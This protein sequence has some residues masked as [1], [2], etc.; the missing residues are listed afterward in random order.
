LFQVGYGVFDCVLSLVLLL[1]VVVLLISFGYCLAFK[2]FEVYVGLFLY[3]VFLV[4][5]L[6][7]FDVILSDSAIREAL[8]EGGCPRKLNLV[9]MH[10][11]SIIRFFCLIFLVQF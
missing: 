10:L 2:L 5:A 3:S 6:D 4:Y 8:R 11:I 7:S 1:H 9:M